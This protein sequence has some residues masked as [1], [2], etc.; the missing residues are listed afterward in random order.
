MTLN[1]F[2]TAKIGVLGDLFA[3]LLQRTI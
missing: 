2:E 1:D 3:F